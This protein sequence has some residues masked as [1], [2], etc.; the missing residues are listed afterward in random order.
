MQHHKKRGSVWHI[1]S[2]RPC[3]Q[4]K[5]GPSS[6]HMHSCHVKHLPHCNKGCNSLRNCTCQSSK[7]CGSVGGMPIDRACVHLQDIPLLQ[8]SQRNEARR[9]VM[10]IDTM[11]DMRCRLECSAAGKP[12]QVPVCI[13]PK[14]AQYFCVPSL[15]HY[16]VL[17]ATGDFT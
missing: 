12:Q 14:L 5:K 15:T 17:S 10:L 13:W 1:V 4:D 11:Y 8:W 6:V 3:D 16:A 2:A 7:W 9:L